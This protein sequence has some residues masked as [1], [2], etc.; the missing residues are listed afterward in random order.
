MR[1]RLL[2]FLALILVTVSC[3]KPH[4]FVTLK[5]ETMGTFY[6]IKSD[7][8]TTKTI[9]KRISQIF[10]EIDEQLNTYIP[11]SDISIYNQAAESQVIFDQTNPLLYE[12]LQQSFAI[13]QASEGYFDPSAMPLISYWGFGADKTKRSSKK[14]SVSIDSLMHFVGYNNILF[15]KKGTNLSISKP[16][17][18]TQ[19]DFSAIAKGYGVDLV[20]EF[21]VDNGAENFMVE[22]GGEVK[23]KGLNDKGNKWTLGINTP[24]SKAGLNEV[25]KYVGISDRA[26]A[27]SGDYRNFYIQDGKKYSHILNP[28][29]GYPDSQLLS[30]TVIAEDCA[31]ADA[32]ATAFMVMDIEKATTIVKGLDNISAMFIHSD[33]NEEL[34]I[35]SFDMEQYL[36]H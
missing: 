11:T 13:H 17:P 4:V 27:S 35:T 29:T 14:D 21:L 7:V 22:I 25:I 18:S 12:M 16:F 28:K 1:C 26:I 32:W 36:L 34:I 30:A 15:E 20:A 9:E 6:T 10:K 5:G 33:E 3:K 24:D 31:T 2:I 19:L 23:T 8:L